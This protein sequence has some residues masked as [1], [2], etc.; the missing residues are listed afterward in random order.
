MSSMKDTA[1][2]FFDACETGQGG[3]LP[4]ILPRRRDLSPDRRARGRNDAAGLYGLDERP[5]HAGAR[6]PI[7]GQ[8]VCRG[9]REAQRRRVQNL[10][11]HTHRRWRTSAADGQESRGRLRVRHG[12]RRR[13]DSPYDEDLERWNQHEAAG[14]GVGESCAVI[15]RPDHRRSPSPS[16]WVDIASD[17]AHVTG[18][19]RRRSPEPLSA[20]MR[21]ID[22]LLLILR[23]TSPRLSAQTLTLDQR[24]CLD[25][26][27]GT[28]RRGQ[29][30]VVDGTAHRRASAR[31][32]APAGRAARSST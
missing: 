5:L 11:R 25:V 27:T 3:R 28:L 7:R 19:C 23:L 6:R 15:R 21:L 22:I 30:I 1:Q 8:V 20:M 2:Q 4:P 31:S 26:S 18:P 32:P 12:L 17:E 16:G 10:S 14:L 9:R 24:D 13:P 29:T